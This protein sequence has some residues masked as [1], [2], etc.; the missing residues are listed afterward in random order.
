MEMP[1]SILRKDS[2]MNRSGMAKMN[3]KTEDFMMKS[4]ILYLSQKIFK[5]SKTPIITHPIKNTPT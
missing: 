2:T 3:M 5:V 1:V 4:Q